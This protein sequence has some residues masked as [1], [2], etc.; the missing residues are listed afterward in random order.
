MELKLEDAI[1]TSNFQ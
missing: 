1:K